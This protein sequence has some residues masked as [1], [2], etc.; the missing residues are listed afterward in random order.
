MYVVDNNNA[1]QIENILFDAGLDVDKAI[2]SGQ[3]SILRES[4]DFPYLCRNDFPYPSP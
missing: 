3:L 4:I 2:N 1:S